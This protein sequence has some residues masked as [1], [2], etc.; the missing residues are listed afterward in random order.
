MGWGPGPVKGG[1]NFQNMPFCDV[2]SRNPSPKA[3]N[4]FFSILT[5]RLAESL[6]GLDSSLAQSPGELYDCK[7]QQDLGLSRD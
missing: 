3:K 1:Q 5:T 7:A 2:T 4:V 6:H